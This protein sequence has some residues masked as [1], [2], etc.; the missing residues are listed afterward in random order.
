MITFA[1]ILTFFNINMKRFYTF[2]TACLLSVAAWA[3]L[4]VGSYTIDFRTLCAD[5]PTSGSAVTVGYNWD[6]SAFAFV[7]ADVAEALM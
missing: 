5:L 7:K 1:H 2:L 6:A 3:A 4:P